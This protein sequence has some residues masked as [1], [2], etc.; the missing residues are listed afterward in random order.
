LKSL[1]YQG[2][3]KR[4]QGG[5]GGFERVQRDRFVSL[6]ASYDSGESRAIPLRLRGNVLHLNPRSDFGRLAG[7]VLDPK[8]N[9]I[10]RSKLMSWDTLDT[11]VDWDEGGLSDIDGPITLSVTPENTL[12]FAIWSTDSESVASKT[13]Q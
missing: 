11:I 1:A 6:G 4:P 8:G 12:L 5:G 10:A 13:L 7:E 9:R 2:Q 3:D